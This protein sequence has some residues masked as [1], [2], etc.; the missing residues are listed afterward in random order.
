[1]ACA[2]VPLVL[3]TAGLLSGCGGGSGDGGVSPYS[4]SGVVKD[5]ALL[6]AISGAT[7]S[8]Q[9]LITSTAGNGSFLLSNLTQSPVPLTIHASG[10]QDLVTAVTATSNPLNLGTLYLAPTHTLG[11]GDVTG[12]V[13]LGALSAVG[14][15]VFSGLAQATSDENG[16]FRL[17]NLP[18]GAQT[19]TLASLDRIYMAQKAVTVVADSTVSAG[20]VYLSNGPPPP[21][22]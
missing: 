6:S 10:H 15:S 11:R 13:L 5:A 18:A 14:V 2:L 20:N 3:I 16:Q 9:T 17:Y 8:A 4:V 12:R 22:L 19:L 7:V 21:P 1:M